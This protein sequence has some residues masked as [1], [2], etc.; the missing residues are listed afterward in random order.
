MADFERWQFEIGLEFVRWSS[1]ERN[2]FSEGS[3][4]PNKD[5]Q[6]IR[7]WG[8]AASRV[9]KLELLVYEWQ[10]WFDKTWVIGPVDLQES[11]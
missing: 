1:A 2:N 9:F 8:V 7:V 11:V 10:I 3:S 6:V 5:T 4:K